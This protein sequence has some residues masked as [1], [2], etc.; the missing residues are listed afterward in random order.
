MPAGS[1]T[2]MLAPDC[3]VLGVLQARVSSTRLPGKV[4]KPILGQPMLARQ[5]ERLRR[6]QRI[7]KLVVATSDHFSDD[8][9]AALCNRLDLPCFRGSL[10]DVLD[11]MYRAALPYNPRYVA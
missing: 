9:I 10:N 3:L 2:T 1:A 11:R 5:I 8:P 7:D 6:S 4:L